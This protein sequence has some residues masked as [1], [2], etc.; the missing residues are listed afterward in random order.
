MTAQPRDHV[1]RA[2][3]EPVHDA[4]AS[5][6][7][8]LAAMSEPG[9]VHRLTAQVVPP[10]G[11]HRATAASLLT[12][13][14]LDTPVWFGPSFGSEVPRFIGFHCGAPQTAIAS[15]ASFAVANA[16]DD[17]DLAAFHPGDD[18]YPDR[19]ATVLVQCAA[20]LGGATV[21]LSGPG[22]RGARSIAPLGLTRSFWRRVAANHARYPLGVD[23][24]LT[25]GHEVMALPRSTS[26]M[27]SKD[28]R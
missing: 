1:G 14:D 28:E 15:D 4:Q 24:L 7:A 22:I 21:A 25:S 18:R 10:S 27:M 8:I 23:V 19:S 13:V 12:L 6:R 3:A 2:F 9:T 11:L 26:I 20:L 5:F 16:T 17:V